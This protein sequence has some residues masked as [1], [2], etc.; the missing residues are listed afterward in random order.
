MRGGTYKIDSVLKNIEFKK[1][2]TMTEKPG[3]FCRKKIS[4]NFLH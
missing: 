3:S 4:R 1:I 2:L